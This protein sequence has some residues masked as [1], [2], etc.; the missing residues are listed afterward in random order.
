MEKNNV[1]SKLM[2]ADGDFDD[3]ISWEDF[4]VFKGNLFNLKH[5]SRK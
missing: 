4:V 2:N 3:Y 5:L 1:S